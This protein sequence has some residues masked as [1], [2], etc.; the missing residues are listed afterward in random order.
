MFYI[1]LLQPRYED[2]KHIVFNDGQVKVEPL[3]STTDESP[4]PKEKKYYK[5]QH[6]LNCKWK[7]SKTLMN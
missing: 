6:Q 3:A 4:K 5:N 2:F 1:F 7:T